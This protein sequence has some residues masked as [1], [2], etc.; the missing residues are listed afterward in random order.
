MTLIEAVK[1]GKRF[2]RAAK[3]THASINDMCRCGDWYENRTERDWTYAFK[4]QDLVADDWEVEEKRVTITAADLESAIDRAFN[5]K[6]PARRAFHEQV[7]Q[8]LG[9]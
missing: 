4:F 3:C 1:S 6:N 9:L 2:R 8:E 7:A 5:N